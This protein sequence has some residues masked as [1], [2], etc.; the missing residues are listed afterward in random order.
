MVSRFL[1]MR[2]FSQADA[3]ARVGPGLAFSVR[4]GVKIPPSLRNIYKEISEEY[5]GFTPPKHGQVRPAPCQTCGVPRS[6][7]N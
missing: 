1:V 6:R 2:S 7:Q 5:P 3:L 4:P